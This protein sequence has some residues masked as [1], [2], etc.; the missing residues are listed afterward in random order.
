[1]PRHALAAQVGGCSNCLFGRLTP[2]TVIP[3]RAHWTFPNC[4]PASPPP[5][6]RERVAIEPTVPA[7]RAPVLRSRRP[8]GRY[9][10]ARRASGGQI[11]AGCAVRL[12][13]SLCG[14]ALR[15]AWR[16]RSGPVWNRALHSRFRLLLHLAGAFALRR[17]RWRAANRAFHAH[18]TVRGL[19]QRGAK[20]H[21]GIAAARAR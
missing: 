18:G 1:M 5:G 8:G 16:G 17:I 11:F 3:P 13:A 14:A 6:R 19:D 9:S 7:A 15:L 12:S 10:S 2:N 21:G 20:A 4:A